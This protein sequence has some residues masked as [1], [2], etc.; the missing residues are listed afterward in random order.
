MRDTRKM[1]GGITKLDGE[2]EIRGQGEKEFAE[3]LFIMLRCKEGR[4]LHDDAGE[5]AMKRCESIKELGEK[6]GAVTQFALVGDLAGELCRKDEVLRRDIEPMGDDVRVWRI[7][8]GRIDFYRIEIARIEF[9]SLPWG[10]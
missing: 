3:R 8:K 9:E 2:P 10:E 1:P 4:E 5:L 7:I 6:I